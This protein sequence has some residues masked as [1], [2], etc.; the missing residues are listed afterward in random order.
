MKKS[1]QLQ[2]KAHVTIQDVTEL[3]CNDS[4]QFV[5]CE[6]S[7]CTARNPDGSCGGREASS[8]RVNAFLVVQYIKGGRGNASCDG[9]FLNDVEQAP[10]L[11]IGSVWVH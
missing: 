10:L 1:D 8:K 11:W 7:K 2:V 6:G 4:L 3:V 9:H 5:S